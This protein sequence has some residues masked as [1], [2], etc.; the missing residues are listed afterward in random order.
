MPLIKWLRSDI[1]GTPDELA[2]YVCDIPL[3]NGNIL[4]IFAE[5][6]ADAQSMAE[7]LVQH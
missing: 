2:R 5:G 6:A 7:R 4:R 1:G 3:A